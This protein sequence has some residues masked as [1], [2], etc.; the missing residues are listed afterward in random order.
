M[1]QLQKHQILNLLCWAKDWTC[2]PELQR[3]HWFHCATAGTPLCQILILSSVNSPNLFFSIVLT[4]LGLLPF[5][6]NFSLSMYTKLLPGILVVIALYLYIEWNI[7]DI[8]I[9]LSLLNDEHR[10]SIIEILI[11]STM[12][13]S[14]LCRITVQIVK[15]LLK[16]FIWCYFKWLKKI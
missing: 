12:L 2:I 6:I 1:P 14:C 9:I 10:L 15:F 16:Y 11:F 13:I 5:H 3:C 7:I 4:V 8:V